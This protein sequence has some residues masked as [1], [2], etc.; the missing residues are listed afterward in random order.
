MFEKIFMKKVYT[1]SGKKIQA[2]FSVINGNSRSNDFVYISI[3]SSNVLEDV[4]IIK[5]LYLIFSHTK[6]LKE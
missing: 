5:H 4:K 3:I 6:I 1:F 2:P